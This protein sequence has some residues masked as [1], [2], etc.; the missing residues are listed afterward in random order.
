[1]EETADDALINGILPRNTFS[2]MSRNQDLNIDKEI[3]KTKV[4]IKNGAKQ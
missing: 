4:V 2:L 3:G 1:M